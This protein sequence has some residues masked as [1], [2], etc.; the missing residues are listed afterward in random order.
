MR[1]AKGEGLTDAQAHALAKEGKAVVWFD[2]GLHATEVLGANQLIETTY[3]LI[4]RNDDETMRILQRR[5]HPRGARESRRHAARRR[6]VHEGQGH[7]AAQ[8]EHSA[9]LQQVRGPRRQ[10]RLR[11]CRT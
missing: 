1:L 3:Q 4:S 11:S 5:H 2:G 7:A 9:A 6:L 8:H 10:S